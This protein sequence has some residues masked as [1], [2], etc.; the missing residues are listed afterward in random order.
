MDESV[1]VEKLNGYEI[2]IFY[3][4]DPFSPREDDNLTEIVLFNDSH[5]AFGDRA[6]EDNEACALRRGGF[7]LLR[8]YLRRYEDVIHVE[9]IGMLDHSGIH[10]WAGGGTHWSDRDG[11]D[12]GTC[13]FALVT[14]KR[15]DE[16]GTPEELIEKA[17]EGEIET[18]DDY[19]NGNVYG[20]TITGPDGD[21]VDSCWGF[22]PS[23]ETPGTYRE[24]YA[25]C[26]EEARSIARAMPRVSPRHITVR[27]GKG[28][29][30]SAVFA[31]KVS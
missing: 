24:E 28:R 19:L 12:S 6:M 15:R 25:D 16:I 18:L 3:D 8:R 21:V 20:F 22:Y 7:P 5:Y 17:V 10:I 31:R 30:L 29:T 11:W 14:A 4:P 27:F 2:K 1:H 13:G 9:P 23:D 26:L